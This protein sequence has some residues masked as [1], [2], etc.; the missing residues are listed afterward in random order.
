VN[1]LALELDDAVKE[2][3]GDHNSVDIVLN[4]YALGAT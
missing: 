1:E 4:V 2:A 3:F